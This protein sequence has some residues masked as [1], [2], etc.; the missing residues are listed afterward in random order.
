MRRGPLVIYAEDKGIVKAFRNIPGVEL[1]SVDRLNLLQ[2][3]PGGHLGRFCIWT[4]SA[5]KRIDEVYATAKKGY[6]LPR[7][8]MANSDLTRIIN[9]DEIQSVVRP[10]CE[11]EAPVPRKRNA[12]KNKHVMM[13]LNPH[14]V[15]AKQEPAAKA[16][17][18][19][20]SKQIR[21]IGSKFYKSMAE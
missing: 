15:I 11:P 8:V 3:A 4:E 7:A 14:A 6:K 18:A 5:M 19:R 9:S 17:S 1:C 12:L 16:K 10:A 21:D 20:P 2:L 13:K